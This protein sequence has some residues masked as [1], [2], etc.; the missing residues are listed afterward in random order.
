MK[1][2]QVVNIAELGSERGE[3]S[4]LSPTGMKERFW[5]DDNSGVFKL[6]P[7]KPLFEEIGVQQELEQEAEAG[8]NN[9]DRRTP[10]SLL[11]MSMYRGQ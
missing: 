5:R 2:Q 10:C 8:E 4:V 11:C 7:G 3:A 6:S 1:D 9:A